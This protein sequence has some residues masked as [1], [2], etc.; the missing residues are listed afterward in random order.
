M[1]LPPAAHDFAARA[2]VTRANGVETAVVRAT[3]VGA[4]HWWRARRTCAPFRCVGDAQ[5]MFM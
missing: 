2:A 3:F 5:R 1:A 4:M